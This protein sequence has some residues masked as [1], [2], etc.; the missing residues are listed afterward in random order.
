MMWLLR[1]LLVLT[2]CEAPELGDDVTGRSI[3]LKDRHGISVASISDIKL[4]H[5]STMLKETVPRFE[6]VL[7]NT[8][9][10][11]LSLSIIGILRMKNGTSVKFQVGRINSALNLFRAC[12][13]CDFEKD[14]ESQIGYPFPGPLFV[15]DD[16]QSL[17]FSLPSSW[18]SPED[19]RLAAQKIQKAA[20]EEKRKRA[21]ENARYAR[22][23]AEEDAKAV[24]ER[25]KVRAAC[26]LIYK[27][28][29]D[30]KINDLTVR[31]EQQVRACQ[32]LDMYPPQ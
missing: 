23:K 8:S 29:I 10:T 27:N 22:I 5:Y 14:S 32:A 30:K 25:A 9:G 20:A 26:A 19:E 15:R 24:T 28:T 16:V 13:P 17:E 11:E 31:E 1:V 4:F 18:Q 3:E 12:D 7:K 2:A 6:G 21:E